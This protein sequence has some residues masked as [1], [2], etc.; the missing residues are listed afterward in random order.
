MSQRQPPPSREPKG[1]NKRSLPKNWVKDRMDPLP[2]MNATRVVAIHNRISG[3]E[4]VVSSRRLADRLLAFDARLAHPSVVQGGI[5]SGEQGQIGDLVDVNPGR[6]ALGVKPK[7][8]RALKRLREHS[9]G[10]P[11]DT[12][13]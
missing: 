2:E 3:G 1:R 6:E 13:E 10:S 7:R 5:E 8:K 4:Y 11:G 9:V 12:S